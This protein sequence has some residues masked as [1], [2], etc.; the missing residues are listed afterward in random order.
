MKKI[1]FILMFSIYTFS[2]LGISVT[3]HFCGGSFDHF[4]FGKDDKSPCTCGFGE[5]KRSCCKDVYLDCRISS[6]QISN[7]DVAT[8]FQSS[9]FIIESFIPFENLAFLWFSD[10]F[11]WSNEY[12]PPPKWG[13][14]EIFKAIRSFRI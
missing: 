11:S 4:S 3:L 10:N 13:G 1:G 7:E 8:T 12:R 14:L 5:M 6:K 9:D 2:S